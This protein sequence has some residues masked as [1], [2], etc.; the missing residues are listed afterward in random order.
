MMAVFDS[1]GAAGQAVADI[2]AAG[3]VPAGMEIM[4][5]FAIEG[6]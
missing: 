6:G 4:D 5:R 3:L 1:V 2:I